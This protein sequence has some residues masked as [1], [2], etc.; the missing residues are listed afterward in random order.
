MTEIAFQLAVLFLP[1]LVFLGVVDR[2]CLAHRKRSDLHF[3]VRVFLAGIWCYLL[4]LLIF[5]IVPPLEG[6]LRQMSRISFARVPGVG[7]L[8]GAQA[9]YV[10][11]T[12]LIVAPIAGT[13]WSKAENDKWV[14][15]M[16][17]RLR[18]TRRFGDEDIWTFA[19]NLGSAQVEYA[20]I[21]DFSRELVY[22][23]FVKAYSEDAEVREV[24]LE[25][26]VVAN[27]HSSEVLFE[28]PMM[29]LSF[30]RDSIHMEFP[31]LDQKEPDD[32]EED[33]S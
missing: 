7:E 18:V 6:I 3:I 11:L 32:V 9:A 30:P 1:G 13:V 21:R 5:W 31:Y 4:C 2:A 29:Y 26:V 10:L 17:Q 16:L 22:G 23:G 8:D 33:E 25:H 14:V 24:L 28:M 19:L 12:S 20:N 15:K 27:L